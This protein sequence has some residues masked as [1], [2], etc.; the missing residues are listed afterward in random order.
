MRFYVKHATT[1]DGPFDLVT[2]VRKIRN[3]QIEADFLVIEDGDEKPIIASEHPQLKTFF[4]EIELLSAHTENGDK[5]PPLSFIIYFKKGWNFLTTHQF[6]AIYSAGTLCICLLLAFLFN[7]ILP[8]FMASLNWLLI[9]I[10]VQLLLSA[11]LVMFLRIHRGQSYDP[12]TLFSILS[13]YKV[14]LLFCASITGVF[15]G[16]GL[17]LLV[18]PGLALM[19]L[20]CF[21]P[22]LII[23]Q[24]FDFW[25][26]MET[27]RKTVLAH[28]RPLFE[29]VFGFALLNFLAG[30]CFVLPLALTLPLTYGALAEL[31]DELK[32]N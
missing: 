14:P 30:I 1:Q 28:G 10:M 7:L 2:M 8:S 15:T 29:I 3:S 32:F 13:H 20:Y 24:N 16:L 11:L 18:I 26:A 6:A 25:D 12:H 19:G 9:W 21:A 5:H 17:G 22:L 4:R 23:D 31:Y 27:S